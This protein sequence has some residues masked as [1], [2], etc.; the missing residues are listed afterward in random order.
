MRPNDCPKWDTCSCPVCPLDLEW[1][2]RRH[3]P[4]ERICLWLRELVKP[5]GR[6]TVERA[7]GDE[8]ALTVAEVAPDI[9][10]R[11]SDIEHKL[12][13]ASRKGSKTACARSWGPKA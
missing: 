2:R 5:D 3:L 7:L 8:A 4:G 9:T 11:W 6:A 1:R 13:Q 10:A 12:R